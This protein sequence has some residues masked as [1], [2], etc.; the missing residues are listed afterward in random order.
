MCTY[1]FDSS[2]WYSFY[3]NWNKSAT[4]NQ[5]WTLQ[6]TWTNSNNVEINRLFWSI[7]Y[8]WTNGV[9]YGSIMIWNRALSPTEIQQLYYW[10]FIK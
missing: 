1:T 9:K 7:Y 3:I 5:S 10:T 4:I 8:Y 2:I 6:P